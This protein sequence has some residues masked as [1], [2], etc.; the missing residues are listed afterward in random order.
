MDTLFQDLRY[1]LRRLVRAPGFTLV[2]ALSLGL[3]IG[4]N[5]AIFSLVNAVMLKGLPVEDVSSLVEIYFSE[6]N[7]YPYATSS[8]PDFV[9]LRDDGRAPPRV[10]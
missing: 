9:A 2:A 10:G 1:A 3:G 8:Y 7:G 5:T 4:A 6:E